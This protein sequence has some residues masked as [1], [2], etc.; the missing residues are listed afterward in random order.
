MCINLSTLFC[1][2][3]NWI[4]HNPCTTKIYWQMN[5]A[6][7]ML[8]DWVSVYHQ[9]WNII[10]NALN[11]LIVELQNF[12]NVCFYSR[13]SKIES[14]KIYQLNL[15]INI[16]SRIPIFLL[17]SWQLK[18]ANYLQFLR[19]I[20]V[21]NGVKHLRSKNILNMVAQYKWDFVNVEKLMYSC[22]RNSF[23]IIIINI[24]NVCLNSQILLF[25]KNSMLM[26]FICKQYSDV[27]KNSYW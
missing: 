27:F 11:Y 3:A 20:I 2:F 14:C 21:I 24:W 10:M 26:Q 9:Y 22:Q 13:S 12:F 8:Y 6:N 17:K 4:L 23:M 25:D 16:F 19:K 15:S 7:L 1:N 18:H 5:I